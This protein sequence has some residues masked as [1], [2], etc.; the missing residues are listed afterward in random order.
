MA[1]ITQVIET[2]ASIIADLVYPNGENQPS[3]IGTPIN[4]I[5]GW[6]VKNALDTM[7][8]DGTSVISVYTDN[9]ERNANKFFPIWFSGAPPVSTLKFVSAGSTVTFYGTPTPGDNVFVNCLGEN[10]NFPIVS[11]TTLTNIAAYFAIQTGGTSSGA[12]FTVPDARVIKV[13]IAVKGSQYCEV[14]RQ[15]LSIKAIVWASTPQVRDQIVQVLE[16]ELGNLSRFV[17]PDNFYAVI[18][19]GKNQLFDKWEMKDIYR[20]DLIYYI[21]YPSTLTQDAWTITDVITNVEPEA[22]NFVVDA[23]ANTTITLTPNVYQQPF[24]SYVIT[25]PVDEYT[26]TI[27]VSNLNALIIAENDMFNGSFGKGYTISN[28]KNLTIAEVQAAVRNVYVGYF[29]RPGGIITIDVVGK[30]AFG[31]TIYQ[32]TA[33]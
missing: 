3:I 13:G 31:K 8:A 16:P 14:K 24:S 15:K 28:R 11:G 30:T 17:L 6:P 12:S 2:L 18:M 1:T 5:P 23:P 33:L 29:P 10:Y 19:H 26:V 4:I 20:Q 32:I 9:N 7:L 22:I 25:G 27:S 21:E